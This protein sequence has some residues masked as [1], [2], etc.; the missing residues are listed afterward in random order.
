MEH[1]PMTDEDI[2]KE[3]IRLESR[4]E[5]LET[6]VRNADS[7][8]DSLKRRIRELID[9]R[10]DLRE[11]LE[12][13]ER[14]YKIRIETLE[15]EKKS[16][17]RTDESFRSKFNEL[18]REYNQLREKHNRL[19]EQWNAKTKTPHSGDSKVKCIKCNTVYWYGEY[20]NCPDCSYPSSYSALRI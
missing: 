19:V 20:D 17:W 16:G 18:V 12:L 10:N 2:G 4:V 8:V 6:K 14:R 3:Y 11:E 5:E 7:T 9:E 13:L 15:D 1:N